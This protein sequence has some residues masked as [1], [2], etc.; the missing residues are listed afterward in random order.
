MVPKAKKCPPEG[1]SGGRPQRV[2][3]T[4]C[5]NAAPKVKANVLENSFELCVGAFK[6]PNCVARFEL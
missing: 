5:A 2:V 4:R 6:V 3:C 1:D